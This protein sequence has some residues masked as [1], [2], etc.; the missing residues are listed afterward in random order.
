MSVDLAVAPR[1]VVL[2]SRASRAV[3]EGLQQNLWSREAVHQ[4]AAFAADRGQL[5]A[6][7][8]MLAF[9]VL[10]RRD[11]VF[12]QERPQC[13]QFPFESIPPPLE[14]IEKG[15]ESDH[16]FI[17]NSENKV[18]NLAQ[19]GEPHR[20]VFEQEEEVVEPVIR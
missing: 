4:D 19:L 6:S 13:P 11:M 20:F 8:F 17:V 15:T 2:G 14:I 5:G 1:D 3:Y 12:D 18:D 16:R 9:D 7:R 10:R